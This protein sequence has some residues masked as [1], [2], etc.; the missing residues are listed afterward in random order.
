MENCPDKI[1]ILEN[2]ILFAVQKKEQRFRQEYGAKTEGLAPSYKAGGVIQVR[3]DGGPSWWWT[4][5]RVNRFQGHRGERARAK[6]R[7]L[8][9]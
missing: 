7:T 5:E 9:N 4:W 8:I 1:F 6:T 3:D 2:V